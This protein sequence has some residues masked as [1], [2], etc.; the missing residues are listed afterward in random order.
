MTDQ[1]IAE[2]R[3]ILN[4]LEESYRRRDV[5]SWGKLNWEFHRRLYAPADRP[6][7][8]AILQNINLQLERYIRLHLL[9]TDGLE[10]AEREHRELVA[11]CASRDAA[12]AAAFVTQHIL[13]TGSSL[14]AA[15]G[16]HRGASA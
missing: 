15:L 14:V 12:G 7:T 13:Q 10:G 4:Q 2:A 3:A 11:L 6:Q 5:S 16:S 9:M 8:L 1:D